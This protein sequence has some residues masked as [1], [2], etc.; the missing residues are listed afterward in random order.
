M[1]AGQITEVREG[2]LLVLAEVGDG[3]PTDETLRA[4]DSIALVELLVRVEEH[5]GIEV[6]DTSLND[7]VFES[8]DN[9]CVLI[10]EQ[11]AE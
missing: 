3:P 6:P 8:V 7:Q 5:F 4:L 1:T 2:V 9:L 11:L 10:S